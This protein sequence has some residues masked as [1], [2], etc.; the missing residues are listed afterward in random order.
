MTTTATLRTHGAEVQALAFMD[1]PTPGSPLLLLSGSSDGTVV[2]WDAVFHTQLLAWTAHT[3]GLLA[4]RADAV[5]G[6]FWSHGRDGCIHQWRFPEEGGAASCGTVGAAGDAASSSAAIDSDAL[7]L[8]EALT[9]LGD[10]VAAP[11]QPCGP[12]SAQL[13]VPIKVQTLRVGFGGFCS[14]AL[15]HRGRDGSF[16][17]DLR[18]CDAG[19]EW[20]EGAPRALPPGRRSLHA[21]AAEEDV[22]RALA[23]EEVAPHPAA[24]AGTLFLAAPS[25]DCSSVE[26]WD[27]WRGERLAVV[28][29]P[30]DAAR[31]AAEALLAGTGA[32]TEWSEDTIA[33]DL[34]RRAGAPLCLALIP[35]PRADVTAEAAV[36]LVA[37]AVAAA[38][39][40]PS[41]AEYT[42]ADGS[43]R[44]PTA[45]PSP[46]QRGALRALLAS[47]GPSAAPPPAP[48]PSRDDGP[49]CGVLVVASF[50]TGA[51]F[52]LRPRRAEGGDACADAAAA[53]GVA[54]DAEVVLMLPLS[55]HPIL[56]F[57]L[58]PPNVH[59]AVRG[60][61]GTAGPLLYT[62]ELDAR[63]CSGALLQRIVL[64]VPGASA[65]AALGGLGFVGCWG[66]HAVRVVDIRP[67]GGGS[68]AEAQGDV[69]PTALPLAVVPCH[70]SSVYAVAAAVVD[71]CGSSGGSSALSVVGRPRVLLATGAKDAR[72]V[73]CMSA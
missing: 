32:S 70:Q 4:L 26:V 30:A 51:V 36:T 44:H 40:A 46:G 66:D 19:A 28:R 7:A 9:L 15:L 58:G 18:G 39:P 61:A 73:L 24:S 45:Q 37:A 72:I 50:E 48:E 52:V 60:V 34:M 69:P 20:S 5:R 64:P 33:G 21:L 71:D 62:F 54:V 12:R 67:C 63:A 35:D 27:A 25:L 49:A 6:A 38:A 53:C 57:A 17:R 43:P 59:G 1:A 11:T 2:V 13:R 41:L 68:S 3:G 14:L 10:V 31:A 42:N 8:A 22:P 23:V 65:S 47:G 56:T 16:R 55:R 29:V